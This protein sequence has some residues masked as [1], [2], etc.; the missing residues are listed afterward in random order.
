MNDETR[1]LISR[2][3]RAM[4]GVEEPEVLRQPVT[5]DVL[6]SLVASIRAKR[7]GQGFEHIDQAVFALG[8]EGLLLRLSA[9]AAATSGDPNARDLI[10]GEAA[11]SWDELEKNPLG[12]AA[13]EVAA[14]SIAS[15]IK[16]ELTQRGAPAPEPG[17]G[18]GGRNYGRG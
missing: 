3:E 14:A 2:T 9:H 8:D 7:P 1:G 18:L 5:L 13:L 12:A 15:Q 6:R 10:E 17:R 16:A 11:Y 4:A